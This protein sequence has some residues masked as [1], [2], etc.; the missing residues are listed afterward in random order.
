M[1]KQILLLP[2]GLAIAMVGCT[3]AP[4]YTR[5]TAPVPAEWPV[6][7]AYTGAPAPTT[8]SQASDMNW[9]EFFTDAKLQRVIELA[10]TNNRD[11]RIAA[12]NV[13][14]ARAYYGIQRAG[15]LPTLDAVGSG[16]KSRVPGDLSNSGKAQTSE[17]YDANLGVAAWEIDFFGRLRSLK[18]RAL[19][20][21]LA[22]EHARRS[23]QILLVSSV[24]QAYLAL[25]ADR[26]NL[27]LSQ[28]TLQTQ[29]AAYEL[30]K[31]RHELGLVTELELF[32]AQTPL[33]VARRDVAAYQQQVAQ[34][35][36]ALNLLAG[37]PVPADLLPAELDRVH[38][39][40]EVSA[41]LSSEVL[42][43]RPDVL[44]AE[45]LL[46]AAN[47]DIGAARAAFFPRVTLTAAIGTASS[48]LSGLFEAGSGAWSYAPRIVMPIFDARTWS[49]HKAAKVQR[50]I[51][52]TQY[53]KAIQAAF[54]E[55]ADALAVRGTVDQQVAAQE[56]LVSALSETHRLANA[57]FEKGLD[58]YLGVLDAQRSLFA[59]QQA[60]VFLRLQKVT[61]GVRLYAVLG[62]GWQEE[63]RPEP[64]AQW[65][66]PVETALH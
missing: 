16:S 55:V 1:N 8:A 36:N 50:E 41:G 62:G 33:E 19:E 2:F 4:K 65:S 17:R 52:V 44:Q 59:A 63:T 10:L 53:E 51:A 6:G 18:D 25:A 58:S 46:R 14:R 32:R 40:R 35:E 26:E 60:L 30:V 3:L 15:L 47:A 66:S 61:S 9:R 42:L 31:R 57:R 5:P 38:P 54:R 37:S 39:P 64:V 45:S 29:Q 13:E 34:D 27:N 24:A 28:T 56:S 48:D 49:A 7:P 21:F 11:L 12:L 22:T 23:A 43:G 20:E